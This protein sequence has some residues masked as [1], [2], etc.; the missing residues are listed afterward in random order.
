[1]LTDNLVIS[2]IKYNRRTQDYNTKIY[3]LAMTDK[4]RNIIQEKYRDGS[5][6]WAKFALIWLESSLVKK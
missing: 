2:K 3:I 6:S 5:T 4:I 1:M